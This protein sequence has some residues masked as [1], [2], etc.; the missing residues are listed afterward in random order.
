MKGTHHIFSD[1]D[2]YY[3]EEIPLPI[4][5]HIEEDFEESDLPFK[6]DLIDWQT[7]S[8]E[9]RAAIKD[10]VLVIQKN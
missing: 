1:L 5:N 2:L 7:A 4:L 9:F 10:N 8:K 3:K 6:V